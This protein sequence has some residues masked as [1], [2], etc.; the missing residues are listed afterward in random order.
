MAR[1]ATHRAASGGKNEMLAEFQKGHSMPAWPT[2][3]VHGTIAELQSA[4]EG[5]RREAAQK[6][7]ASAARKRARKLAGIAA[8]PARTI[9]ETEKLVAQRGTDAYHQIAELLAD[10]REALAGTNQSGL[11][12]QQARKLK[13]DNPTLRHL[14]SE[15]RGEGFLKK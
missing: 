6:S 5:I 1:T 13:N 2:A 9:H 10:L 12:E 8:D 15:L 4:A 14:V 7:A 3:L 11:A